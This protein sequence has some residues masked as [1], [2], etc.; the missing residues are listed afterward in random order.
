MA[1]KSNRKLWA[2]YLEKKAS[3]PKTVS[4]I[5]NESSLGESFSG[6]VL[7]ID[8]SLRGAGFAVIRYKKGAAELLDRA[9]LKLAKKFTMMD[10]LG[11]IA[12][13][14]DNLATAHEI[15]HVAVEQT[16]YVQN[17]QTAQIMGAARGA[18]IAPVA[19]RGLSVFEY[20]P[21]R[22]KQAIVGNGRASKEQV[23]KMVGRFLNVDFEAA[24][25]E[26]DASAVA[27]CHAFTW[28]KAV[29]EG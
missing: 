3:N 27:L 12:K 1:K 16:I 2:D 6:V 13:Q 28:K 14:V 25:D 29:K 17:F 8:P 4:N 19:M 15:D 5:L 10:C 7:G 9:T 22:I 26:S 23:A 24:Y 11:E 20:A 18:A 21:L